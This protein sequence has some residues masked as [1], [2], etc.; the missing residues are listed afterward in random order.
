MKKGKII[1]AG[2][3]ICGL[4]IF[5]S[6]LLDP[7]LLIIAGIIVAYIAAQFAKNFFSRRKIVRILGV[8]TMVIFWGVSASLYFNLPALSWIWKIIGARSGTDWMLNSGVFN[9]EFTNLPAATNVIAGF[10]F[11]LYPLWLVL[12]MK[13]G[14]ILFGA[15]KGQK[16]LVGLLRL[17]IGSEG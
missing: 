12:G 16:G 8:A 6:F 15:Q 9:F 2:A 3:A 5:D 1:I 7:F 14:T 17:K 10:L 4:G 13:L 11:A